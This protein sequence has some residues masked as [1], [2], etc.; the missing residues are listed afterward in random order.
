MADEWH[1]EKNRFGGIRRYRYDAYGC[2]EY[3]QTID[4][5]PESQ[6][7]DHM[8]REA[9]Q[10]KIEAKQA[11]AAQNVAVCPFAIARDAMKTGCKGADC[12]LFTGT[13]CG[14]TD[15]GGQTG[16]SYCPITGRNC[17]AKCA[18][19]KKDGCGIRNHDRA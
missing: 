8:R 12:A 14:L 4:G 13:G 11:N 17:T 2:K 16:G 6:Y 1:I 19:Y 5:I 15:A 7:D 10:R 9:E 3:E 18:V